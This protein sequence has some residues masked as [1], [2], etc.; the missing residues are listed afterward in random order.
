MRVLQRGVQKTAR[1]ILFDEFQEPICILL[2][3]RDPRAAVPWIQHCYD[4][5]RLHL[6][7]RGSVKS[8]ASGVESRHRQ[9]ADDQKR[10]PE[11]Q[12]MPEE[13]VGNAVNN[14]GAPI[15]LLLLFLSGLCRQ[16]LI[17]GSQSVFLYLPVG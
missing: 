10:T 11:Q 2:S 3:R 14:G 16:P 13:R 17:I 15:H 7:H 9:T 12:L 8:F 5:L 4:A 1:L 6:G